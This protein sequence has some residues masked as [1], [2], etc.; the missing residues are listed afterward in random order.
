MTDRQK[1]LAAINSRAQNILSAFSS[2]VE[3]DG[4]E[5]ENPSCLTSSLKRMIT[6]P[7][8]LLIDR[9]V[10]P[11]AAYSLRK[12]RRDYLGPAIRVRRLV[13][14]EEQDI[15]FDSAGNLDTASL[16]TF[17]TGTEGYV[18]VWYDQAN[19]NDAT[20]TTKTNQPKIYYSTYDNALLQ[21]NQFDTNWN[22]PSTDVTPNQSGYDGSTDAWLLEA[23]TAS[24]SANINQSVSI[25]GVMTASIYAKEGTTNWFRFSI[26]DSGTN[27]R[28]WFDLS[29]AGAVGTTAGYIIDAKIESAGNGYFRCSITFN[30]TASN[31]YVFLA[32]ADNSIS[33]SVGDNIYIQDAQL[34]TGDTATDYVETTTAPAVRMGYVVTENGKPAMQFDGSD[35]YLQTGAI[36]ALDTDV[37]SS[38]VVVRNP[39]DDTNARFIWRSSY[40]SGAGTTSN[41]LTG[42]FTSTTFA[43]HARSS[44]GTY[45]GVGNSLNTNQNLISTLWDSSDVVSAKLN[46]VDFGYN[47]MTGADA[48]P[49]GHNLISIGASSDPVQLYWLGTI[50]SFIIYPSDQD[51]AGNRTGIE[52]NIN[53]YY[54]IYS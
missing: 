3:E 17:C 23:D 40:A 6:G 15:F 28:A 41:N 24:S 51:A 21:S 52:T 34:E 48:S 12:L 47:N 53:D 19:G 50:Q 45:R 35:D 43:F 10:S 14:A 27:T 22:T 54:D 8:S 29:G 30:A 7:D 37:Q 13:D 9:Y 20:Q 2:R 1:V 4:G 26:N 38:F 42:A 39:N 18:S 49:S 44:T 31:L 11:A 32:D 25:S 5:V 36:S 16:D 46:G 33:Y